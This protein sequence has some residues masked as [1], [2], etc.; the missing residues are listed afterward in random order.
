MKMPARPLS[1]IVAAGRRATLV[2][3]ARGLAAAS[4]FLAPLTPFVPLA[5]SAQDAPDV[6]ITEKVLS[7]IGLVAP[8]Q[9]DIDYRERAPLVVPPNAEMLPPPRDANAVAANPQW[10]KDF[11]KEQARREAALEAATPGINSKQGGI[12]PRTL[13]PSEISKGYKSGQAGGSGFKTRGDNRL[14]VR[15][16][17]FKGWGSFGQPEKPMVFTGEPERESLVQP[18]PGYQTPSPNAVYGTVEEKKKPWTL[19][20]LFDRTQ[21]NK[22]N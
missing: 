8:T 10:P 5:A 17:D 4:L 6:S 1:R 3:A 11:D 14:S 15:E 22:D 21:P 7:G 9:P 18:P 16:L 20:S 2:R 13:S 19:P 12:N